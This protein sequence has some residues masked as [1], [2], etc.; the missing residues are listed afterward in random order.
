QEPWALRKTDFARMET[1]LW[2]TLELLRKVGLLVQPV[3]PASAAKL[4]DLLGQGDAARSFAAFGAA[5]A[6]GT[7]LP[8]PTPVFP[9]YVEPEEDART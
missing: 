8:A 6:T 7:A 3:M 5:I 2:V 1:V 4:L 9:K